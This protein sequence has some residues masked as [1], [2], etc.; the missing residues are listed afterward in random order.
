MNQKKKTATRVGPLKTAGQ[1][2]TELARVYRACRRG[3]MDSQDGT[4]LSTILRELR[5]SI[6]TADVE[7]RLA[8]LE[9]EN[10]YC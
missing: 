3:D 10:E 4:R 8:V 2:A 7:K 1:V 6:E 5:A 9:E